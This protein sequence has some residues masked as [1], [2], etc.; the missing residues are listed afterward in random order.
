MGWFGVY[1][2]NEKLRFLQ[3]G[4]GCRVPVA[5]KICGGDIFGNRTLLE[6]F[7]QGDGAGWGGVVVF[8]GR[9]G[10]DAELLGDGDA[11]Y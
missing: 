1:S 4:G 3:E 2:A 6:T 8:I 11:A 5:Q 10:T 7:L 9:E